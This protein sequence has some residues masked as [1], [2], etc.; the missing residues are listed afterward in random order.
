MEYFV[1]ATLRFLFRA[2]LGAVFGRLVAKLFRWVVVF[3]F[4]AFL[5]L[6]LKK[7]H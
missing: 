3:A 4:V 6:L 1:S 2:L 7:G 5:F